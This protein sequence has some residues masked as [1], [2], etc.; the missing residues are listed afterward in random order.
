M[1]VCKPSLGLSRLLVDLSDPAA[2]PHPADTVRVLQTHISCIFL[3]GDYAYKIKKPVDFGFVDYGA[4]DRRRSF[5]EQEIRLNRRLCPD[6]YL[7][8]VPIT[9][10][11]GQ[12]YAGGKD[13]P[14]EWAVQMRRLRDRDMLPAR[15]ALGTL[16]RP[17]IERIAQR[18]AAF[19]AQAATD[20]RI[21]AFG[22]PQAIA[23]TMTMTLNVMDRNAT[24][25]SLEEPRQAIRRYLAG[26]L[27][28]ETDLL[29]RR[30]Q[31]G[32]TR[33][34]HGDLRLQNIC[35]DPRYGDGIQIFDCIEFNDAL[36]YID[37]AADVAYLAM[38][39]DLA[40][41]ADLRESLVDDYEV[42]SGDTTLR[43]VLPFYLAYRACV[44]GNI[45]L[46]AA[47]EAEMPAPER[48]VQRAMAATAYD[49]AWSYSRQ[50]ERPAL[51][52]TAGFSGSG[53]SALAAE[54]CRRLP[55]VLLSSDLVRKEMAGIP[56]T[57][58]LE[59][60]GYALTQRTAVYE[61]MRRR[62]GVHL[63]RGENVLLDA[64]FL[65]RSE[66]AA[67]GD[68]AAACG[69]D[70]WLL[71]CR[72]P[73][74]VIRHRL[75]ERADKPGISDADLAVYEGQRRCYDPISAEEAR[76]LTVDTDRPVEEAAH[77]VIR[78]FILA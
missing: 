38:D 9:V 6:V 48:E 70:L 52:L 34:G 44:R 21:R 72:C 54:V 42:A 46:L 19:H 8:V 18:L 15:L 75:Q 23:Q 10:S 28:A 24:A 31:E 57:M 59:A 51:L 55:A 49:L 41:R 71:E 5:C 65:S 39:L 11:Y 20:E 37:T 40:G 29:C 69:A 35:L 47:G 76:V 50:R 22:T 77:Q 33:D 17:Q 60:A 66:R 3:A 45:A 16:G 58:R 62:A 1:V 27:Q 63:E 32:R 73:D 53:K 61:E 25:P 56:A 12:L 64:T 4:L 26:F 68:L 7:D 30:M 14:V 78:E 67:A 13:I 43:Q 2:Y 74:A 36:R